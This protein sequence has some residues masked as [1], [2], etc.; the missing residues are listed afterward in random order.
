MNASR[1]M[2]HVDRVE[3]ERQN[4]ANQID[5]EAESNEE[6]GNKPKSI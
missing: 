4:P 6:Y 2:S 1:L 3:R 5:E